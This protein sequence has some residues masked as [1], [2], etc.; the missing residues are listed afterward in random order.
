M[1]LAHKKNKPRVTKINTPKPSGAR[2]VAS[3]LTLES[4]A[5]QFAVV[6]D[7]LDATQQQF[8]AISGISVRKLSAIERGEQRPNPDDIRRFN[9][10]RRLREE[11]AHVVAPSVIG[12]WIRMPN[13][14]LGGHSPA[15][16]IEAGES[17]RLWRLIWQLQD[18][19]P[20]D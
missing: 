5:S 14:Y 10:L 13:Q 7:S 6:R 15:H 20:L 4:P 3:T 2:A 11:L 18:N 1:Q 16:L 12:D 8:S 19:I 17:D 9:E